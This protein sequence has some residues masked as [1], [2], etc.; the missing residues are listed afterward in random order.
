MRLEVHRTLSE[1]ALSHAAVLLILD[2]P[3]SPAL[4]WKTFTG[5]IRSALTYM[6]TTRLTEHLV[7][8][9]IMFKERIQ[10]TILTMQT[11]VVPVSLPC[12]SSWT[13]TQPSAQY[14][15]NGQHL[16]HYGSFEATK[17]HNKEVKEVVLRSWMWHCGW[18]KPNCCYNWLNEWKSKRKYNTV[19][20]MSSVESSHFCCMRSSMK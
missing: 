9:Q 4:S 5:Q 7:D 16:V 3:N 12:P 13:P 18:I 14:S 8:N 2:Q 1:L 6:V 15:A 17:T 11:Q 10:G 20:N 19:L